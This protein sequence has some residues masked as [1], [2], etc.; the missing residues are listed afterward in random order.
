MP[1]LPSPA[2]L[3]VPS[4]VCAAPDSD[5]SETPDPT[6]PSP[7]EGNGSEVLSVLSVYPVSGV[8]VPT[9]PER[10]VAVA[11]PSAA[12]LSP[13]PVA[14]SVPPEVSPPC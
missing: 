10:S 13:G 11:A 6:V 9:S 7:G 1:S 8:S 4:P 2:G 14:S 5:C 12:S 3:P